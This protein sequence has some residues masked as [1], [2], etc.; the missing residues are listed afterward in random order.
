M[1]K[2]LAIVAVL[3]STLFIA[4]GV[5]VAKGPESVTITGPGIDSQIELMDA[6]D[7]PI[8]CDESCPD[9]PMVKL[10][11]QT[12][13]WYATGDLPTALDQPES[14]E[15]G[16]RHALTWIR[17][18]APGEPVKERR[19]RQF[20]YLRAENG[21]LIHTREQVGLNAWGS[22]VV[23]WSKAPYGIVDTLSQLGAPLSKTEASQSGELKVV[24][25]VGFLILVGLALIVMVRERRRRLT[26]PG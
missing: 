16:P 5:A 10:M 26:V 22:G 21:P 12:G 1:R 19:I 20:F 8:S 6:V 13:I 2:P 15:L 23:G 3:T 25:P 4:G 24:D 11:E 9:D 17:S 18:G 7:W 14:G